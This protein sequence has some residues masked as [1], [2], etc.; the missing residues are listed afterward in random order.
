MPSFAVRFQMSSGKV[1]FSHSRVLGATHSSTNLPTSLRNC[2]SSSL[3]VRTTVRYY[4]LHGLPARALRVLYLADYE[5]AKA[6]ELVDLVHRDGGR[7]R[8]CYHC[9]LGVEPPTV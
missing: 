8:D 7:Y 9:V 5:G 1:L 3:N 4:T 6:L 2:C